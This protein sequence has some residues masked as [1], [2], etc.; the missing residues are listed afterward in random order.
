[1]HIFI[2]GRIKFHKVTNSEINNI[3]SVYYIK[4]YYKDYYKTKGSTQWNKAP[5]H[6]QMI[7]GPRA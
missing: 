2:C 6:M 4:S 1:M 7:G 5:H 3:T